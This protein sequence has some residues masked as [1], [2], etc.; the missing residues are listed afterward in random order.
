MS[1]NQQSI[2][3]KFLTRK[4]EITAQFLQLAEGHIAELMNGTALKRYT[5][6]EFGKKLFIHPRHLTNTLKLTLNTS[7]CDY[8]EARL[9]NEIQRLL[10]ETN[11][12][13]AEIGMRFAYDDAS[14]FTKFYKGMT[15]ITPGEFRK[16]NL[17]Q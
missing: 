5:A 8:M 7:V 1:I 9:I 14:N 2:P 17:Q 12:S 3:A 13:I 10:L 11:L 6:A 4:D 15:G 16:R